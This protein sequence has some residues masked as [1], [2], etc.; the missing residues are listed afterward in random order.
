ML[1]SRIVTTYLD[2]GEEYN[3]VLQAREDE[4]ATTRDLTN[5]Y[6]RS[7]T[8]NALIPLGSL[9]TFQERAG[10]IDLKRF[11]RLRSITISAGLTP[12]YSLSEAL[13]Y[14]EPIVRELAP[15]G[16]QIDYEGESREFKQAGSALYI[17]FLLALVIV[18]LVLAAQFESFIHPMV[19]MATVPLALTGALIG[20]WLFGQSINVFSQIGAIMLIGIAAKNGILIVEFTNQLRDRGE[21]FLEAIVEASLVRLRPVLMTSLCTAFGAIPL[22]AAYGAGAE[23]R[24][25][26]GAAVFFGVIFAVFLTLFV[27]PALY[28]LVARNTRS[29]EYV[30]RMIERLQNKVASSGAG[31]EIPSA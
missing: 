27:V 20:L 23:S 9:V 29:P 3:V 16:G 24:R 28:A 13:D 11:N 17:T 12:G 7:E 31:K 15:P 6:V 10:P 19:I 4:R 1:G 30:T 25:P 21:E 14:L 18:F 26:I 2:R 8:S 22:L 5:I